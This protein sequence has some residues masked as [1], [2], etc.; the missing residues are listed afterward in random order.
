MTCA[1]S[2]LGNLDNL[3]SHG[4]KAQVC[5]AIATVAAPNLFIST[6]VLDG[7]INTIFSFPEAEFTEKE[8]GKII[9]SFEH[10]LGELLIL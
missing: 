3:N 1:F 10:E 4:E 5:E 7:K 2:N 9:Q 6:S 8:V